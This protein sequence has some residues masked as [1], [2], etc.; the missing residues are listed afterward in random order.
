MPS[1]CHLCAQLT[2]KSNPLPCQLPSTPPGWGFPLAER[3]SFQ[4]TGVAQAVSVTP[5][6]QKSL[7]KKREGG[8]YDYEKVSL[9]RNQ[10]GRERQKHKERLWRK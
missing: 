10:F 9:S 1:I 8:E 6:K 4:N 3:D 7:K 5:N 2:S